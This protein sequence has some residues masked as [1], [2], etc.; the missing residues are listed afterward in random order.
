VLF[1]KKRQQYI[2]EDC[3]Q[4]FEKR[5]PVA[6]ARIFISYGHDEHATLAERLKLDLETRGH[7][8]WF[9]IERL[10]PGSDWERYIEEGLDWV[11][12]DPGRGRVILLMTP[13]S[14]R[15]PDGY[16]L[17]EIA[18]ALARRV[19]VLPVM[20]VWSEPPLSICRIQ[21]LDMQDCVPIDDRSEK[22]EGKFQK[23]VD[24]LEHDRLGFE[25]TQARLLEQLKPL[26]FDADIAQHLS[27]FVGRQWVFDTIDDWLAA[28]QASRVFW[29][30]GKPGIGKTAIAAW[31]CYHRREIAAF[32]LCRFG[33]TQK[34]DPRRCV[35]SIAYQLSSQLP[36]YQARVASLGL[37]SL[38]AESNA[39]TLFDNLIV[40]PLSGNFPRPERNVVIVIDAL[41]EATEGGRNELASFIASEFANTPDWLRLIIT[42]RPDPEVMR[43]LQGMTPHVLDTS[44][45]ENERDLRE[46]LS[47]ELAPL[48]D[49]VDAVQG[50]IEAI[51]DRSEGVF[52]YVRW[53]S[54]ELARGRLS[55]DRPEEFPQGLGG[56]YQQFFDR[57][58]LQ[59]ADFF[60]NKIRPALEAMAAAREPIEVEMLASIFDWN[61]YDRADFCE[62]MGSLFTIEEGRIRPFHQSVIDWLTDSAKAG[63]Y[64]VSVGEG[65]KL[66]ADYGWRERAKGPSKMSAYSLAHLPAHLARADRIEDL[67]E[68]LTDFEYLY[69]KVATLG[70]QLLIEDFEEA[71]RA[72][73][74]DEG[75]ALLQDAL[76]LSAHVLSREG[77][78]LAGH[79]LG[80]L[81][82]S[83]E[84]AVTRVLQQAQGWKGAVW[85]KPMYPT[86]TPPGGPLLRILE[87]HDGSVGAVALTPGGRHVISGSTDRTLRVWDLQRGE[88]L[89]NLTGHS[90][91]IYAVAVTPDGRYAVSGSKDQTLRVWD[92]QEGELLH[93]LEGHSG[94]IQSVALTS[95]GSRAVSASWDR[96]LKVWDLEGGRLIRS[97]EG[98]DGRVVA[99]AVSHDGQLAISGATDQ[100]L[101]VWDLESGEVLRTL[102]GHGAAVWSVA[103]TPDGR[104]AVSGSKDQT[105]KVWDLESGE[106]I[107]DLEG[108]TRRV[109]AVGVTNDGRHVISGSLDRTLKVWNLEGGEAVRTLEG[110]TD[111]IYTLALTA[112]GRHLVSGAG[113]RTIRVWD[114]ERQDAPRTLERHGDNVYAVAFTPDGRHVVSGSWDGTLKVWDVERGEVL[115]NLEGHSDRV[116]AVAVTPDGRQAVSG[117]LDRTIR[118]WDIE[119]G[120][121]LRNL[122]GHDDRVSG[123]AFTPEGRQMISGSGDHTLK[124]WDLE[125]GDVLRTLE[126]H[127]DGVLSLTLTP[128]GCSAVS[129]SADK[130]LRVWDME[131]GEAL[132]VLE[133]HSDG[134]LAVAVN[135]DSSLAVSGSL[136]RT[137]KVWDLRQ[138]NLLRTL[139]HH[140]GAVGAVTVL[141]GGRHAVS[142]AA[143]KTLKVWHLTDGEI[144]ASFTAEGSLY[145]C[146][147]GPDGNTVVA[148][149]GSGRVHFL[150]LEGVDP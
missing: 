32:H 14:V 138:G 106:A 23:L 9:D 74:T 36:D 122:E 50:A 38:V 146:A 86:L 81:L 123:I 64:F 109:Q 11:G 82:S 91:N 141:P 8:V 111:R 76:R 34:A 97:L 78:E 49:E 136:D 20:V 79:L 29:I 67:C 66:L 85:L 33:H 148:G 62:S 68:M 25:G 47:H 42:S 61:D 63:P 77:A 87:G 7:R 114:L 41:D 58:Y 118:V 24:A 75:L 88:V 48:G 94:P 54:E 31:L 96:T 1:S 108:H 12:Q 56:V 22:Y 73:C 113:D 105:L 69:T 43:P 145:C 143:D 35:L 119:R 147:A 129:G 125:R 100:M 15:R 98:H 40:Q 5:E 2:C 59:K 117:S 92:L 142:G 39:R 121:A 102:K 107:H 70:P 116:V 84:P 72:G 112:D 128:D 30:T 16:C 10:Q 83:E 126:G 130:T 144:V 44:A 134:V 133:G 57:Q 115:R 21:W 150:C 93:T 120:H 45:P 127:T 3:R 140:G 137:I 132:H 51:I 104:H 95:D 80:R 27:R 26:P 131:R 17:N 124:V 53:A 52:L 19:M 60:R 90:D 18:R 110:H 99:V 13:H 71:R 37:E 89:R 28:P 46:Y 135:P 149:D 6:P 55:V 4:A 101:K 139:E 65:H 103:L